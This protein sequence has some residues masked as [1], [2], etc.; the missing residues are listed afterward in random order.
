MTGKTCRA[1]FLCLFAEIFQNQWHGYAIKTG[2]DFTINHPGGTFQNRIMAE[3]A[4]MVSE[5]PSLLLFWIQFSSDDGC[6]KGD[7]FLPLFS[8]AFD[9]KMTTTR[10]QT[11]KKFL[12]Q[13]VNPVPDSPICEG[14]VAL[15]LEFHYG[16]WIMTRQESMDYRRNCPYDAM[17]DFSVL[18]DKKEKKEPSDR[19]RKEQRK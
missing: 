2:H 1:V 5:I 11:S 16:R 17:G 6:K 7:R 10:T 15:N 3:T 4:G 9:V 8:T 14:S 18:L 19:Q 12:K 13:L